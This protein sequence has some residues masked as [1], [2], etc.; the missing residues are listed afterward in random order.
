MQQQP[1]SGLEA[2]YFVITVGLTVLF[3]V[4]AFLTFKTARDQPHHERLFKGLSAISLLP[5]G[6]FLALTLLELAFRIAIPGGFFHAKPRAGSAEEAI[7]ETV[8]GQAYWWYRDARD[9]DTEG[10]RGGLPEPGGDAFKVVVLGDSVTFGVG[11][12]L[13]ESFPYLLE[14]QLKERCGEVAFYN[15]AVPGYGA[16][17]E[18]ISLERNGLSVNPDLVL[19]GALSNDIEQFTVIGST[20]F[21]IRMKEH[22]GVPV[23]SMLPLPDGLNR[24]L[25]SNSVFYQF[26]TL[27]G[28]KTFDEI[29]GRKGGQVELAVQEYERILK[30]CREVGADMA[31]ALFPMLDR[32]LSEPEDENTTHVYGRLREW[33]GENGVT[34]IEMRP[35]LAQH[36]LEEIRIDECCHLS[37]AGHRAASEILTLLLGEAGVLPCQSSKLKFP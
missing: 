30:G 15:L 28:V 22:N 24:F 18:R 4:L 23:F 14:Q 33:A 21:D 32:A 13:V 29:S 37:P 10:Y 2:T 26:V 19:I 34:I 36:P 5:A 27:A 20:A 6:F 7:V 1:V 9:F 31:V 16:V 17:Q 8:D 35:E 3:L 12:P 25:V 11:V